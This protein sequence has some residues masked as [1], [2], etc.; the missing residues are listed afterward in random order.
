M[1]VLSLPLTEVIAAAAIADATAA[2]DVNEAVIDD[3]ERLGDWG[4]SNKVDALPAPA[5]P[6]ASFAP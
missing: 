5:F 6:R 3:S 2:G 4:G 1:T